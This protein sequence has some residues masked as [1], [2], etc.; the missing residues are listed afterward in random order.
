MPMKL[1]VLLPVHVTYGWSS[2][3]CVRRIGVPP[4]AGTRNKSQGKPCACAVCAFRPSKANRSRLPPPGVMVGI[5]TPGA[6][7]SVGRLGGMMGVMTAFSGGTLVAA[8]AIQ[9]PSGD[10]TGAYIF[11]NE[12]SA[13]TTDL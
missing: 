12:F 1:I 11:W 8:N 4:V 9:F 10:I 13:T 2:S 3:M 6:G 5:G 7:I